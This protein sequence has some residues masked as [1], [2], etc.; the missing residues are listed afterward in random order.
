M[1]SVLPQLK[2]S[3]DI[4]ESVLCHRVKHQDMLAIAGE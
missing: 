3:L 2:S 4:S 1:S